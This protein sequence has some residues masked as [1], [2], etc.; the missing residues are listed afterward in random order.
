MRLDDLR[1]LTTDGAVFQDYR[2]AW[3][4]TE[5]DAVA[6]KRDNFPRVFASEYLKV[7]HSGPSIEHENVA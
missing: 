3:M 1:M 6:F 7:C 2:A 5:Y 4:S